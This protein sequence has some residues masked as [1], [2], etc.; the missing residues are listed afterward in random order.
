MGIPG[1]RRARDPVERI[2]ERVVIAVDSPSGLVMTTRVFP[3]SGSVPSSV[4]FPCRRVT[5]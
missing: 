1:R 2:V 3:V 5:P 4:P